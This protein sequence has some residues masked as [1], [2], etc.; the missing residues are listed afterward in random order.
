MQWRCSDA[1]WI[2]NMGKKLVH[3]CKVFSKLFVRSVLGF[4]I[5]PFF[6][7]DCEELFKRIV[8]RKW[9]VI[10]KVNS[11]LVLCRQLMSVHSKLQGLDI[12]AALRGCRNVCMQQ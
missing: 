12:P 8:G 10:E 9:P 6:V 2:M 7:R 3:E 4:M 11:D 5:N 1:G